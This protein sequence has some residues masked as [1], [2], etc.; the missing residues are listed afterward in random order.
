M[1]L[2]VYEGMATW[3]EIQYLYLIGENNVAKREERITS[4][5]P[6]EY[7]IGFNLYEE[8]YP[9]SYETM[10]CDATPFLSGE[11]PLD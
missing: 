11:A 3:T 5:R 1:R 2:V 6:D 9:L 7:G 4:M 8:R 10:S